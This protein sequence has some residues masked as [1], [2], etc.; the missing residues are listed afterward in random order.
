MEVFGDVTV[1][2]F[3][4]KFTNDAEL[5]KL[6]KHFPKNE[7]LDDELNKRKPAMLSILLTILASNTKKQ[8]EN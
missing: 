8:V 7:R 3:E 5:F 4:S 6:P 2:P 1:I